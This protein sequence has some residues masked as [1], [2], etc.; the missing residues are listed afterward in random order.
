MTNLARR[1]ADHL[2]QIDTVINEFQDSHIR[3]SRYIL[4]E[5]VESNLGK[6]PNWRQLL[7]WASVFSQ[8]D[9]DIHW[10]HSHFHGYAANNEICEL[11][12][13]F[14]QFHRPDL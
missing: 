13:C 2:F 6:E 5:C 1:L 10:A 7:S 9:L 14:R 8:S 12:I 11:A 3:L 4:S